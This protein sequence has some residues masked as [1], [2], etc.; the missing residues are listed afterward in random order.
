MGILLYAMLQGRVPYKAKNLDSLLEA[1]MEK[2]F[3]F[4]TPVSEE[5]EDLIRKM[6]R[7]NPENRITIPEILSHPWMQREG[8]IKE[9]D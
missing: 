6:L 7:R 4:S 3:G 8:E 2:P 5:A 9:S 1:I